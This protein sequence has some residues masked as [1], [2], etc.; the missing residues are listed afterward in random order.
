MFEFKGLI[1]FPDHSQIADPDDHDEAS[2]PY[3]HSVYID[4]GNSNDKKF[5]LSSNL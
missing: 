4:G 3:H 2:L 5:T 1:T